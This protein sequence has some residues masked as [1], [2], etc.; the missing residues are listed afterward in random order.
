MPINGSRTSFIVV[1]V[2]AFLVFVALL[3][4][5]WW[6]YSRRRQRRRVASS[7][8][9]KRISAMFNSTTTDRSTRHAQDPSEDDAF[10]LS[11]SNNVSMMD[12]NYNS[13]NQSRADGLEDYSNRLNPGLGYSNV[14]AAS[15][16]SLAWQP[17]HHD[18]EATPTPDKS[19][20]DSNRG[21]EKGL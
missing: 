1:I 7:S 15:G 19:R 13:R 3:A 14:Y 2:I 17:P 9:A 10:D 6:L 21:D 16:E 5:G 20:F 11:P 4:G 8:A 18:E 12:L